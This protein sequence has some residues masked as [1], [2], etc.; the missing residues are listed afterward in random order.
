M[1]QPGPAGW[2]MPLVP[3][4]FTLVQ[5]IKRDPFEQAVGIDQKTAMSLGGALGGADDR[6][7]VRLEHAADRPAAV[8]EV[9]RDATRS[10]RRCRRLRATTSAGIMEQIKKGQP[11]QRLDRIDV[12]ADAGGGR[13]HAGARRPTWR[14]VDEDRQ[15]TSS[16]LPAARL[17]SGCCVP[18]WHPAPHGA[19]PIRC[20]HGTTARPSRRSSSSCGDHHRQAARRFVP[21]RSASPRSTRTARCGSSIRCTRQVI[22]CLDRVPALVK[23]KPELEERRAVQDGAVRQSRGDRQAADGRTSRRSSPRRS[24]A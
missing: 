18:R 24:P 21:G 13:R 11:R 4:H 3:F 16:D 22:Y 5:N 17:L 19:D 10:S 20:R 15:S 8:A 14:P 23:A 7:P 9:V 12:T 2:I 1:S 6:L